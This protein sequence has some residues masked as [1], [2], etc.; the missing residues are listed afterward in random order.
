VTAIS[1]AGWGRYMDAG[2]TT[3]AAGR[4]PCPAAVYLDRAEAEAAAGTYIE[5]AGQ[6]SQPDPISPEAPGPRPCRG[7]PA[8]G[9]ARLPA[10][11]RRSCTD[12]R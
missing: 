1:L 5:W 8:A 2:V 10:M 9:R 6:A 3:F 7:K 11:T 4:V 12:E